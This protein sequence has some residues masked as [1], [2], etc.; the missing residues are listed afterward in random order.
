[1]SRSPGSC[2][3]AIASLLIDQLIRAAQH[4]RRNRDT[5]RLRGLEI[6]RELEG[7]RALDR[8]IGGSCAAQDPV[9]ITRGTPE[10]PGHV[11]SIGHEPA[12]LAAFSAVLRSPGAVSGRWT[13]A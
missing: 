3:V 11:R 6:D 12:I 5:E 4:G 9:D 13:S 7:G 1:M 2:A 10:H 8:Q